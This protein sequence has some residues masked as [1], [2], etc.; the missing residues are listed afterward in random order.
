[1]FEADLSKNRKNNKPRESF[2]S[3]KIREADKSKDQGGILNDLAE[4]EISSRLETSQKTVGSARPES[5]HK[6]DAKKERL[7]MGKSDRRAGD[8]TLD[9]QTNVLGV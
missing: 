7:S 8:L 1:V 3:Q 9:C 5:E 6:K 4:E 2:I